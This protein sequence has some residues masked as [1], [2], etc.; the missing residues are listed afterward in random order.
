M[1][2]RDVRYTS[3]LGAAA[4]L[5]TPAVLL[6]GRRDPFYEAG[7][8]LAKMYTSAT[9]LEHEQGHEQE[10]DLHGQAALVPRA[11]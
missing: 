9:V 1:P 2:P 5:Q 6:L 7:H 10:L 11:V 3:A 4:P 8:R